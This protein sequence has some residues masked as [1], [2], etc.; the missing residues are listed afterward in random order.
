MLPSLFIA[1]INHLRDV[2][3]IKFQTTNYL[4]VF[5]IIVSSSVIRI[6][7]ETSVFSLIANFASDITLVL[8]FREA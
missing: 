2:R 6:V 3:V 5:R 7:S 4:N 1:F 8:L